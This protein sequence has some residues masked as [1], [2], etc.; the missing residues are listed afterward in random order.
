[1][2]TERV[3]NRMTLAIKHHRR[4]HW[5]FGSIPTNLDFRLFQHNLLVT[6]VDFGEHIPLKGDVCASH[7][8]VSFQA[9]DVMPDY[10]SRQYFGTRQAATPDKARNLKTFMSAYFFFAGCVF[11]QAGTHW[12][13]H[14]D[15]LS[16]L[17]LTLAQYCSHEVAPL[18]AEAGTTSTNEQI[19]IA[20]AI[21][22][23]ILPSSLFCRLEDDSSF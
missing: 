4:C 16:A 18:C 14:I 21:T 22:R 20:I 6:D 9:A 19:V 1:M 15:D 3:L 5:Y 13:M 10:K 17:H 2:S 7:M 11:L 23:S 12:S 8:H